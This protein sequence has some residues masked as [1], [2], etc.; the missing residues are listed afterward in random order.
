M[1][2]KEDTEQLDPENVF[3]LILN[4]ISCFLHLMNN[5]MIEPSSAYYANSLGSNDAMSG[6]MMGASP[7]FAL[8]SSIGYSVWTNYSYRT[9]LILAG[10]LQ[11][12]GNL[13]Y[14]IANS[15]HSMTLCLLGRAISGLGAPRIMNRR[16]VADATPFSLRTAASA[17]F[18]MATAVGAA[19]GPG[20]AIVLDMFE[21][22]FSLP[23][24]G[25]QTFNGMT[26]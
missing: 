20:M 12:T 26:G 1:P 2:S 18:A 19:T 21:F 11:I 9:P 25:R 10:T 14:G 24:F 4:L 13:M 22:D 17:A 5:Y 8:M 15:Y 23:F 16:Y 7:C 3:P 6:L